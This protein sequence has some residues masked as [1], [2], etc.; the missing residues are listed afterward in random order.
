MALGGRAKTDARARQTGAG[1]GRRE[2]G[3]RDVELEFRVKVVGEGKLVR[4]EGT[5][6][7]SYRRGRKAAPG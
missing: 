2:E 6:R 3:K 7:G 1:V 5:Q 4:E